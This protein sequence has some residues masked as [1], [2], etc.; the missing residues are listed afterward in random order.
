MNKFHEEDYNGLIIKLPN[1]FIKINNLDSIVNVIYKELTKKEIRSTMHPDYERTLYEIENYKEKN[2][3]FLEKQ[4][5]EE[6][7]QKKKNKKLSEL[8]NREYFYKC[9]VKLRY[10]LCGYLDSITIEGETFGPED[11]KTNRENIKIEFRNKIIDMG[12]QLGHT[13]LPDENILPF[14][15]YYKLNFENFPYYIGS[16]G[17]L[18]I[19]FTVDGLKWFTEENT[20][21]ELPIFKDK[22]KK[23]RFYLNHSKINFD[24][25]TPGIFY[26]DDYDLET[27]RKINNKE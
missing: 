23:E 25:N 17:D 14:D 20:Y 22:E 21:Y 10:V 6:E 15:M 4:K 5:L 26:L 2:E 18:F 19:R 11:Y 1:W 24:S 27:G 16:S 7:L 13:P 9:D 3:M 8:L 12:K